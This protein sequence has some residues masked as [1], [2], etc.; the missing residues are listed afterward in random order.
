LQRGLDG[1]WHCS[2]C[3]AVIRNISREG[4]THITVAFEGHPGDLAQRVLSLDD[5]EV[6]RCSA[7]DW[8]STPSSRTDY[9]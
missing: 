6:H 8:V 7:I 2:Q 5:T 3:D 9:R 4:V 1:A